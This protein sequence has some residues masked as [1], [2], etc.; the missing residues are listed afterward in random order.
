[1]RQRSKRQLDP[2]ASS[3]ANAPQGLQTLRFLLRVL[4]NQPFETDS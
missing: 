3:M 1:M 4:T 2:E